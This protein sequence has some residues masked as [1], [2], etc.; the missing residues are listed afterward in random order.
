MKK[1][2]LLWLLTLLLLSSF[3]FGKPLFAQEDGIDFPAGE[4]GQPNDL[5]IALTIRSGYDGFYKQGSWLPITVLVSNDGPAV[6]GTI[7]VRGRDRQAEYMAPITLPNQSR[8]RIR[9]N[10][11]NF[12]N[13]GAL[14]VQILDDQ[15]E[16]V[17]AVNTNNVQSLLTT[18]SLL[19]GVVS[20]QPEAFEDLEK[21]LAG[22][23][24][25]GVAFLDLDELPE[26]PTLWLD[27]DVLVF[28]D[29]DTNELTADQRT[30]LEEWIRLGGQLVVTGGASWQ[31]T[32][33]AFKEILP[34]QVTGS[35]S[36]DD[37]PAVAEQVGLPFRDAGPYV[38][39]DSQ[40]RDGI[41]LF[42][43][44]GLPILARRQLGRG[45]VYF[46]ALDPQFAPLDDWDGSEIVWDEI[47]QRAPLPSFWE[48]GFVVDGE[49]ASAVSSLPSLTL[50]SVFLLIGFVLLYIVVIGPLNYLF[51]KRQK[52]REIAWLTIPAVI[53]FF[54]LT[55][56][57][58][59]LQFKGN[60]VLINQMAV[61]SGRLDQPVGQVDA[62]V[63]VYS[64]RRGS[65]EIVLEKDVLIRR[66]QTYLFDEVDMQVMQG[67]DVRLLDTLIDVGEVGTFA[68]Q[69]NRPLPDVQAAITADPE[70]PER[71]LVATVTNGGNFDLENVGLWVEGNFINL[72]DMDSGDTVV[73]S[74]AASEGTIAKYQVSDQ[75]L[76]FYETY[77]QG[78]DLSGSTYQPSP[79]ESS[80]Y[81][82]LG[83]TSYYGDG[84]YYPRYEL[85]ESLFDHYGVEPIYA[86]RSTVTLIAWS[87]QPQIDVSLAENR[88]ENS[89]VTVYF[90]EIPGG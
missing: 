76:V 85:L 9:L 6:E 72:G 10:A 22:R 78:D 24:E 31:K 62:G 43:Q 60:T 40:L 44:A 25:A 64:P 45:G 4:A 47:A 73:Q 46:L 36:V 81:D 41:A 74:F 33:G 19:Y 17:A 15:G 90:L 82:I 53:V 51:L 11:Y 18:N 75:G 34:V 83:T 39:A 13:S 77:Q 5:G 37:L 70:N 54:S 89:S 3:L 35:R 84:V 48:T 8:K 57:L 26:N 63:G 56:Y 79:L 61:V 38:V 23:T 42:N 68:V 14:L 29:V 67:N 66:L 30:A 86:P 65:Y 88:F 16:V 28:N 69:A 1:N 2:H 27:L 52:R 7:V 32:T 49:A 12:N 21:V 59:G 20:S 71:R 80:Y 87:D 50:P 58:I 55:A